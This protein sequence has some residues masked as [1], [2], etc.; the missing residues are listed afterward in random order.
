MGVSEALLTLMQKTPAT[1]IYR[2]SPE[3]LTSLGLVTGSVSAETLIDPKLCV[4][5][6][7]PGNC[8]ARPEVS[9]ND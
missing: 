5:S 1:D 8:V 6:P 2:L 7:P 3:E 4:G 9:S